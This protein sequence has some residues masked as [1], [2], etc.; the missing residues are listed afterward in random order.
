VRAIAAI[1]SAMDEARRFGPNAI[2]ALAA[3]SRRA[4]DLPLGM[5]RRAFSDRPRDPAGSPILEQ[6]EAKFILRPRAVRRGAR[7]SVTGGMTPVPGPVPVRANRC[8]LAAAVHPLSGRRNRPAVGLA[9]SAWVR[10]APEICLACIVTARGSRGLAYR[11]VGQG[12]FRAAIAV[13]ALGMLP[14]ALF[15]GEGG[16][17]YFQFTAMLGFLAI[18][19]AVP[20]VTPRALVVLT[21]AS[22][23]V[24]CAVGFSLAF[25]WPDW[26]GGL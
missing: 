16:P 3:A 11:R 8:R 26:R 6:Y 2:T 14:I 23:A 20:Y 17:A 15:V 10:A 24:V 19:L 12:D 21:L 1:V 5:A 25:G 7:V 4:S 9:R 13:Q 18:V 22:I